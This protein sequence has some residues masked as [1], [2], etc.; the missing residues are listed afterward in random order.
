LGVA[1]YPQGDRA[2]VESV[3]AIGQAFDRML[4]NWFAVVLLAEM[5]VI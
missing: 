3:E 1:S 5:V 4:V 2:A